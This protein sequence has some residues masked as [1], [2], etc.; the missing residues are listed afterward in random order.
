MDAGRL[1]RLRIIWLLAGLAAVLPASAQLKLGDDLSMTMDGTLGAGYNAGYGNAE[2]SGHTLGLNGS[3]NING[4]Y[5]NPK[6]LTFTATPYY[7]RSQENSG[8]G[9]LTDASGITIGT[10]IFGGSHFPGS[11]SWG[12]TYNSTGNYGLPGLQGFTTHGNSTQFGIGWA[13]VLPN[14]PTLSTQYTQSSSSSSVYGTD[15]QDNSTSR[16]L[17]LQSTYRLAGWWMTGH[18]GENFVHTELPSFLTPNGSNIGDTHSTTFNFNASHKLPMH[19]SGAFSYARDSFSSDGG[20]AHTSGSTDNFSANANFQ[21]SKRFTTQFGTQYNSNLEA[22]VEQQLAAAGS[23]APQVNLGSGSHSLSFYN[24]DSFYILRNLSASFN[25]IRMQQQVYGISVSSDHYSAV[26][27]YRF[28]K[29]LLGSF[30]VYGGVNDQ[31]ADGVNQGAGLVAGGNFSRNIKGWDV[32][33]SL[34]YSQDVET[35]LATATTSNYSYLANVKRDIGRRLHWYTNFNGFHTGLSTV[36]GSSS[37]TE[38]YS[39]SI[40]YRGYSVSGNYSNST[41]TA[42]LTQSGLVTAPL[43]IPTSLLGSN[44]YLLISGTSYGLSGSMSPF[45]KMLVSG[46]YSHAQNVTTSPTLTSPNSS[47]ILSGYAQYQFRKMQFVA[48]YTHLMQGVGALGT[49]PTNFTTY[50]FGIQRWFKPF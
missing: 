6:F 27:N 12:K 16:N 18:F 26:A 37:H 10:G 2:P 17:N 29:P 3:G 49:L 45:R 4:Y 5:Y 47:N 14:L 40:L 7:N 23:I 24:S 41:G 19:G 33:A 46:T 9:S 38:S 25:F 42:L 21:P 32:G 15:Q 28:Q 8:S 44:Q 31:A 36:A 34:G 11:I 43:T 20:T 50:Y 13:A 48:G 39:T 35:V 22:V 1:R 30:L